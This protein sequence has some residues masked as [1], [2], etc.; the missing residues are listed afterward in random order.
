MSHLGISQFPF[1][2]QKGSTENKVVDTLVKVK[3]KCT[4][5][6]ALRLC[7]R[8]TA[9]KGSRGIALPL[10]DHGTRRVEGSAS[11]PVAPYPQQRPRTHCT[12]G[13]VGPRVG[14][15]RCRKSRPHRDSIYGLSGPWPVAIPITLPGPK[16]H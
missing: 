11:R 6:Q 5:V 14:L 8:R 13:W 2:N 15:D 7:T 3:V 12:R 16:T 9:H 4:L 10:H 1:S